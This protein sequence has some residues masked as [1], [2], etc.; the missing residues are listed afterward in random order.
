LSETPPA[1]KTL[2]DESVATPFGP[3]NALLPSPVISIISVMTPA[4]V[5]LK[6][7]SEKNPVTKTLPDKSVAIVIRRLSVL[8]PSPV[9]S[10]I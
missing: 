2:P 5:I 10:M 3:S 8:L 6:A 4:G 7:L 9:L 1:T